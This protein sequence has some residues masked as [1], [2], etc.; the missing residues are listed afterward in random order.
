M[1]AAVIDLVSQERVDAAWDALR[2]HSARLVDDPKLLL[3]RA[4]MEEQTRLESRFK[5]LLLA[6][7]ERA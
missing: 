7:D 6:L 1:T 5:R 4:F 2:I 3:D